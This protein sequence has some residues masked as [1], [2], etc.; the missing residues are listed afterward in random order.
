MPVRTEKRV[1]LRDDGGAIRRVVLAIILIFLCA[2]LPFHRNAA[3][4]E[5]EELSDTYTLGEI[6]V[7]GK[8]EGVEATET[9]RTVTAEDIRD[10]G[11]RTLDQAISLLPGVNVRTGAK[12]SRA[13]ISG[14]S[15]PGT[16]SC[17][18]TASR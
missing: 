6:V 10:K 15:A 9:V 4:A 7:S 3:A 14:A 12:G 1:P 11:A 13:S 16:W 8:G 17:F 18:S 2:I 5:G